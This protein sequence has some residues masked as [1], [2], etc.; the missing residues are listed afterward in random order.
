M[1]FHL[2]NL[3]AKINSELTIEKRKKFWK[4]LSEKTQFSPMVM[5]RL[6][7]GNSAIDLLETLQ[8]YGI[9]R[10]MDVIQVL[11][12]L[13]GDKKEFKGI[14]QYLLKY[15]LQFEVCRSTYADK[16]NGKKTSREECFIAGYT[17]DEMDEALKRD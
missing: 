5:E 3:A 8:S 10:D 4:L 12:A 7:N 2:G 1:P 16:E 14:I 13:S 9:I 15:Q 17:K 6:V 11:Q